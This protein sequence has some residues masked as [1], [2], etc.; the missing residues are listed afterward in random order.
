MINNYD[1]IA[2]DPKLF[3]A[4]WLG[5]KHLAEDIRRFQVLVAHFSPEDRLTVLESS[6]DGVFSHIER[7]F[8]E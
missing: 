4:Y 7:D 3:H 1:E 5:R 8:K 6:L 2:A